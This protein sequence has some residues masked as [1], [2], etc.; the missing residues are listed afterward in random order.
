[1]HNAPE[2]HLE[3]CG[4]LHPW[5]AVVCLQFIL[6]ANMHMSSDT[7]ASWTRMDQ[8][9]FRV[10]VWPN[11]TSLLRY[12]LYQMNRGACNRILDNVCFMFHASWVV[13]CFKLEALWYTWNNE[14]QWA[15]FDVA[16]FYLSVIT[17]QCCR[18]NLRGGEGGSY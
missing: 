10:Q 13:L 5:T 3:E 7:V 8:M 17:F 2:G 4:L 15:C 18:V 16:C 12:W 14:N 1:M 6:L 9:L 11:K